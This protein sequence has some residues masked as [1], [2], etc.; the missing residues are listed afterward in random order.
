MLFAR[1]RRAPLA[2]T[3][4]GHMGHSPSVTVTGSEETAMGTELQSVSKRSDHRWF[5]IRHGYVKYSA[6]VKR[7]PRPASCEICLTSDGRRYQFDHCHVHGWVRGI[8]CAFCNIAVGHADRGM[9]PWASDPRHRA[10]QFK[11]LDCLNGLP[12]PP[13][14]LPRLP[15]V[16]RPPSA[17]WVAC[18]ACGGTGMQPAKES[19]GDD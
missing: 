19:D 8:L 13:P 14:R 12:A 6:A 11:C 9:E 7:Y 10:H 3:K 17:D 4:V 5:V 16:Q 15:K 2:G 1:L 18:R